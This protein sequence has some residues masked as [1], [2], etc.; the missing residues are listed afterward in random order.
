MKKLTYW[1]LVSKICDLLFTLIN[2]VNHFVECLMYRILLLKY[3]CITFT[4]IQCTGTCTIT[5][6]ILHVLLQYSL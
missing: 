6:H 3:I 4:Q 2:L 5:C 1:Y